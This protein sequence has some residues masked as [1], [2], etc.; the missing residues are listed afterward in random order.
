[1]NDSVEISIV[2]PV[3]NVNDYLNE[4]IKSI[5]RQSNK[6]FELIVVDD[7]FTDGS[8]ILCDRYSESDSRIKVI[9]QKKCRII[10]S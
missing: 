10:C 1:M 3:Y 7:G 8:Q 6:N 2:L 5:L 4:C 9:H